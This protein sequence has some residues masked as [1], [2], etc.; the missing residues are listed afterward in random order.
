MN[1]NWR[2]EE[3][4]EGGNERDCTNH[5]GWQSPCGILRQAAIFVGPWRGK[6]GLSMTE[7]I[8]KGFRGAVMSLI[9]FLQNI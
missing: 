8:G 2:C 7:E 3:E 6:G 4:S 9:P 5:V 1:N